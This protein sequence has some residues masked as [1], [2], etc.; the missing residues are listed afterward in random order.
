MLLP[1]EPIVQLAD[2]VLFG[3]RSVTQ[4]RAAKSSVALALTLPTFLFVVLFG[5]RYAGRLGIS[6]DVVVTLMLLPL[7]AF[8]ATLSWRAWTA[9]PATRLLTAAGFAIITLALLGY[10]GLVLGWAQSLSYPMAMR[11]WITVGVL[12]L[13]GLVAIGWAH[14]RGEWG[15]SGIQ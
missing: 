5:L 8:S 11:L 4:A 6:D 12:A 9:G 2:L 10:L 3:R 7:L 13:L 15:S 1:L 14:E